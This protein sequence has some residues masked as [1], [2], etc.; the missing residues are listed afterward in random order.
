MKY[1]INTRIGLVITLAAIS[2]ILP[3]CENDKQAKSGKKMYH[4]RAAHL[5]AT[6]TAS[7]RT[8]ST[9]ITRTGTLYARLQVNIFNQEE[10][11]IK[12][13]NFYPGDHFEKNNSLI[14]L[15]DTLLKAQLDKAI[16]TRRQAELDL[17]RTNTLL[18]KGLAA[19]DEKMRASTAL[20]VARAEEVLLSTRLN[21]TNIRAPFAGVVSERLIEVGDIAPRYS[22]LLTIIDPNSMM[23]RVNVSELLLPRLKRGDPASILIDALDQKPVDG[24]VQRIYPTINPS[25]RQGTI[26]ISLNRIP[27]DARPGQL[28]RVTLKT[29]PKRYLLIPFSALRRDQQGEFVFIIKNKKAHKQ[30]VRTGIRYQNMIAINQGIREG[31]PVIIKGF[32]GLAP[33]KKI[34]TANQEK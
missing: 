27:P 5:V 33:G 21:F 24:T 28:C 20:R 16:A 18:K 30:Y 1:R 26:E 8:V 14:K 13:I 19:N 22:H 31:T 15:D 2:L 32:L 23:T 10:G 17:K 11:R 4:K 7:Y 34:T 29:A 12:A 9:R 25:S 6:A 3:A